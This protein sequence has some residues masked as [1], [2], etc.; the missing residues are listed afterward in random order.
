MVNRGQLCR[1][2][3]NT[4][5]WPSDG[6]E[7]DMSNRQESYLS[8]EMWT[9]SGRRSLDMTR[10]SFVLVHLLGTINFH[11]IKINSMFINVLIFS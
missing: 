6:S 11:Q 4:E 2:Y 7:F 8:V 3:H 9:S 1:R 5:D 10:L